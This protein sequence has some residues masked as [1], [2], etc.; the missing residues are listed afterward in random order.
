MYITTES[1]QKQKENTYMYNENAKTNKQQQKYQ[2]S[3]A[4]ALK[5]KQF[6]SVLVDCRRWKRKFFF[7]TIFIKQIWSFLFLFFFF[8]VWILLLCDV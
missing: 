6:S 7:D 3:T 5:L 1:F 8:F 2:R 4:S